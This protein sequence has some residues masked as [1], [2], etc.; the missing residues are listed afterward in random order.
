MT[1]KILLIEDD[2]DLS[3][4]FVEYLST[5]GFKT[6]VSKTENE[7]I[8]NFTSDLD[9]CIFD[10]ATENIN[11]S[12]LIG[13]FNKI[14]S[15]MPFVFLYRNNFPTNINTSEIDEKLSLPF[16]MGDLLAAINR[17]YNK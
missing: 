10:L 8:S 7:A 5:K 15:G 1:H 14:V 2:S 13:K 4:L 17:I 6:I 3:S 16:S 11:A 12:D 9:M